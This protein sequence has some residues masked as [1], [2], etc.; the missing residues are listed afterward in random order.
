MR[1]FVTRIECSAPCGAGPY[2]RRMG[3]AGLRHSIAISYGKRYFVARVARTA[4]GCGYC[5]AFPG[6][7]NDPYCGADVSVLTAQ[8]RVKRS[9][10]RPRR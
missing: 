2:D 4:V 3:Y 8:S 1:S 7:E 5:G 10:S 6:T 9:E